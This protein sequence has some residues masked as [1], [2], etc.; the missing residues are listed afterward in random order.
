MTMPRHRVL[1]AD[2]S[3]T[4]QHI[5]AETLA[6]SGCAVYAC[7]SG[8]E[9][10]ER[11]ARG[12]VDFVC[13]SFYLADMEGIE[14]CRRMRALTGNAYKPFVLLTSVDSESLLNRALPAGVTDIFHKND[15][16]QLLAFIGRFPFAGRRIE[17][18][19]LYVEDS[20]AQREMLQGM[21]ESHGLVVDAFASAD[22]AWPHFLA[23]QHD[24]VLTDIVL[25]GKMS[26]LSFVNRI[27][28]QTDARGDTP[29]LALTAFDDKTRR[30]ELFN[31]GV[32]D[33][34]VK[35][36]VEEELC[37]RINSL[38]TLRKLNAAQAQDRQRQRL[39][40]L[41]AERTHELEAMNRELKTF[42]Y[43]VSHDL[44]APLRAISGFCNIIATEEGHA[45]SAEGRSMLERVMSNTTRM[46]ELINNILDYSQTSCQPLQREQVDLAQVAGEVVATLCAEHPGVQVT[47]GALPV[48]EGDKTMLTQVLQNLL[49]NALKFSAGCTAAAVEIGMRSDDGQ[50]VFYVRD[51][52]VG[53]DER[54]ADKLFGLFQRMH[55][56]KEFPGTGIG[57]AIVKR[58]IERHGGEVWAAGEPGKGAT[59][60]F[61]LGKRNE[62]IRGA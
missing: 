45:L 50:T 23:T 53:F 6:A 18:R 29:I 43:S 17:G 55:T 34:I 1:L 60:H 31:L 33:Y 12:E 27:R 22:A 40:Q 7:D 52:G 2:A 20:T 48:V 56:Q 49:G 62:S 36:V 57:L 11:I 10:L 54:Y 25:D 16:A 26:G 51:N 41:V 44:R 38:I 15:V 35:P 32:T 61:T 46:S 30:M 59:F 39:E 47:I 24:V 28:R 3:R 8:A 4:F 21:L 58:L 13:S 19:V 5:L 9:A 42:S 14:L 37:V